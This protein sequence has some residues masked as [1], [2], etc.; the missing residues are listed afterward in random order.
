MREEA[1]YKA[2]SEAVEVGARRSRDAEGVSHYKVAHVD[3]IEGVDYREDSFMR[4]VRE[5]F[6]ISAFGTNAWRGE[7]VGDRLVPSHQEDPGNE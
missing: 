2:D 6:G 1:E 5:H 4:P 7:S 3:E